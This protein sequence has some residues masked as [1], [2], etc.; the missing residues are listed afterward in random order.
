[1]ETIHDEK[2]LNSYVRQLGIADMFS[3]EIPRLFLLHYSPGELLTTPFSPSRY[4]QFIVKG[5]LLL[6]EMPDEES[7]VILQTNH[8]AVEILGEM[9]LLDTKFT[10][11]F[12]EAH[13]EVYTL[14]IY[15]EQ[16]RQQLLGDP[17]FLCCLCRNLADKLNGAVASNRH[18]SLRQRVILS[19]SHAEPGTHISNIGQ[20][21][22]S[23]NVSPRQLLRVLKDLCGEGVLEH[24][25]KGMYQI[26]KKPEHPLRTVLR[27]ENT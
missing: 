16:Y 25:G 22:R 12:V 9:E 21:A 6:Y 2:R 20:L 15:L 1:M 11:F 24:S 10:P 3:G 7:T 17:V 26:I 8:N 23:L 19:L 14:A 4:L 18:G 13:S 27:K 5:S